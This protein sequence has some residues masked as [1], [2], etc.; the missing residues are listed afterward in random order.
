MGNRDRS[1][2]GFGDIRFNLRPEVTPATAA[3]G[4]F[5]Q[6][7]PMTGV[8]AATRGFYRALAGWGAM[9]SPRLVAAYTVP[10]ADDVGAAGVMAIPDDARAR[11]SPELIGSPVRARPH[12]RAPIG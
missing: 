3:N 1:A 8:T 6:C 11:R 12:A 2:R 9:D 10:A 7:K 5:V 4:T